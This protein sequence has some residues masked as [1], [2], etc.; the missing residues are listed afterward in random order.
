MTVQVPSRHGLQNVATGDLRELLDDMLA[1]QS[2]APIRRITRR[3]SAMWTSA[4]LEEV[5]VEFAD[6]TTAA[7]L[8]KDLGRDGL[9]DDARAVKR[10]SLHDAMR[11]IN[12]YG[13]V[14]SHISVGTPHLHGSIADDDTGRYWLVI[15]RVSGVE[16]FQVGELTTWEHVAAWLAHAHGQLGRRVADLGGAPDW[17]LRYD[18][19]FHRQ[20]LAP[21]LAAA[22]GREAAPDVLGRLEWLADRHET[23]LARLEALPATLIHGELYASN[24]LVSETDHETR[25]CA[26]DWEMAGV[27]PA[28][29]DLAALTTGWPVEAQRAMA[30]A[31]WNALGED[32]RRY[33]SFPSL[34]E[35]LACCQLQ[36]AIQWLGWFGDH[37]PPPEHAH[38]WLG[39]AVTLAEEMA[40]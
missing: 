1:D 28:L 29:F 13:H 38:D 6:D 3:P 31:Y 8:V 39:Q 17:L 12:V 37:A 26:V 20:W 40:L 4:R 36:R 25:V 10:E 2:P 5:D 14:L 7:L 27:G 15:E 16:L 24:V 21:A 9:H 35:G 34:L 23:L 22:R 32:A 30:Q 18:A 33:G 19:A 11:E